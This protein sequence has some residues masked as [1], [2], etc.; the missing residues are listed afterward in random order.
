MKQ[1]D[2]MYFMKA[3]GFILA[4]KPNGNV[5]TLMRPGIE[6]NHNY[7]RKDLMSIRIIDFD[8]IYKI[9]DRDMLENICKMHLTK[10]DEDIF[11]DVHKFCES[12]LKKIKTR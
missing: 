1:I 9:P 3:F 10:M 8:S 12:N 5:I 7:K 4:Q 11:E 2:F 6:I